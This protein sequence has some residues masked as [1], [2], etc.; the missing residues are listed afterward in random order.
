MSLLKLAGHTSSQEQLVGQ[1]GETVISIEFLFIL[2]IPEPWAS[3][4][5][6]LPDHH[7]APLWNPS[8]CAL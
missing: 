2:P 6:G 3:L 4:C 7:K 1:E 5:S 8:L